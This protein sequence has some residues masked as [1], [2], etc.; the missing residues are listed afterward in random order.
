M[1]FVSALAVMVAIALASNGAR[2]DT[3]ATPEER[4]LLARPDF[5]AW[6]TEVGVGA[7]IIGQCERYIDRDDADRYVG[8][9]ASLDFDGKPGASEFEAS[10]HKLLLNSYAEGRKAGPTSDLDAAACRR[11]VAEHEALRARAGAL[12]RQGPGNP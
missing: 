7:R 6:L 10:I 12:T 4:A 1:K 9:L 8:E 5:Q 11:L 2:A 3:Q